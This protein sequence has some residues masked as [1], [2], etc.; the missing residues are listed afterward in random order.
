MSLG[1]EKNLCRG[2]CCWEM[3]DSSA[4]LGFIQLRFGKMV[5]CNILSKCA[6]GLPRRPFIC[7]EGNNRQVQSWAFLL[8]TAICRWRC[9]DG[10]ACLQDT[11]WDFSSWVMENCGLCKGSDSA[12]LNFFPSFLS[13]TKICKNSLLQENGCDVIR[14]WCRWG[15]SWG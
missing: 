14:R 3:L 5:F 7:R 1:E 4:F 15:G 12:I 11:K 2:D 9:S 6:P 10:S 13:L 8:H